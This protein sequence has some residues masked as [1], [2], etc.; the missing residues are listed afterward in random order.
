[1]IY[2]FFVMPFYY[3]LLQRHLKFSLIFMKQRFVLLCM[4]YRFICIQW[5]YDLWKAEVIN[6]LS[7]TY[8]H[9]SLTTFSNNNVATMQVHGAACMDDS[10]RLFNWKKYCNKAQ[11]QELIT[12]SKFCATKV[13]PNHRES[14]V[15]ILFYLIVSECF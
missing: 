15:V 13:L 8:I 6:Q 11:T 2:I 4:L 7:K 14:D 12:F 9:Y 5:H 3:N 1:M 10:K